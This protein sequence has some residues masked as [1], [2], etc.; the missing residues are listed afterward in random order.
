MQDPAVERLESHLCC[1]GIE[2]L[3]ETVTRTQS[4]QLVL[5]YLDLS[6]W[7]QSGEDF[8]PQV[9]ASELVRLGCM[10]EHGRPCSSRCNVQERRNIGALAGMSGGSTHA[11]RTPTHLQHLLRHR[12]VQIADIQRL[13][14]RRLGIHRA[15]PG[16]ALR[17]SRL[18]ALH[19]HFCPGF[20]P[21]H[22]PPDP[23]IRASYQVHS[24]NNHAPC[25]G[26]YGGLSRS[27]LLKSLCLVSCPTTVTKVP[28]QRL[29][30][31]VLPSFEFAI[32]C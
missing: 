7:P 26:Q 23:A 24:R 6:H 25:P 17:G 32:G 20:W 11:S 9:Q 4:R 14:L 1:P 16:R 30:N 2:V 13:S 8:L 15:K 3:H 27:A 18:V 22:T 5:D 19:L 28:C 12:A 29:R 21:D 10:L 31:M